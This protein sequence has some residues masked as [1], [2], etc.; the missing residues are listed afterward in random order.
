M[1]AQRQ[2]EQQAPPVQ[3]LQIR[4]AKNGRARFMSHRDFVRAFERALRRADVPMAYSS[5]FNPHPRIS[6]ANSSPTGAATEAEYL[7][8]GLAQTCDPDKVR[9][10]L[11]A[12][13][14]DGLEIRGIR[15][16]SSGKVSD[17]LEA[18]VWRLEL[19]GTDAL[20]M[21]NAVRAF[22]DADELVTERMTKHGPRQ[23]DAR[24]DVKSISAYAADGL[25]MLDLVIVHQQP[26]VRPD[27]VLRVL[28]DL[29]ADF[30]VVEPP[31]VTRIAQ[32]RIDLNRVVDPWT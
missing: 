4:Y 16:V 6:Y 24:A 8:I 9:D 15:Q 29:V 5:G 11:A 23:F 31:R 3:R 19:P 10:A 21:T 7:E 27:D 28:Q 25:N 14:P 2:P 30:E 1:A 22:L 18:S 12:A 13:L 20:A 32:G 26:L 17:G